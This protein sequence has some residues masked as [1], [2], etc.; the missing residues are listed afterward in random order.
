M[1]RAGSKKNFHATGSVIGMV[2]ALI[3]LS[4]AVWAEK[5]SSKID[6]KTDAS[7]AVEQTQTD[8][9]PQNVTVK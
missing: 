1:K 8:Q 6:V 2:T 9:P 3:L 4:G 7:S 5:N